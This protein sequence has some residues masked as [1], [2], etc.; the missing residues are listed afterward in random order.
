MVIRLEALI[1]KIVPFDAVVVSS[2]NRKI[3]FRQML[4]DDP[5][6]HEN[7][8]LILGRHEVEK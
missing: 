6:S 2:H 3:G 5:A 7:V 1:K 4:H 8:M